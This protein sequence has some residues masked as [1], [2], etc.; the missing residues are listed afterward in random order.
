MATTQSTPPALNKGGRI[1]HVAR[2]RLRMQDYAE[3]FSFAVTDTGKSDVIIRFNWLTR[4]PLY[5]E[6]S[7]LGQA[8]EYAP[9]WSPHSV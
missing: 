3:V 1:T 8:L 9:Y 2:M 7:V 6:K 4:L 5:N